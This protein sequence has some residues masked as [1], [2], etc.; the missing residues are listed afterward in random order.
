MLV[1]GGAGVLA[2]VGAVPVPDA[3]G[4]GDAAGAAEVGELALGASGVGASAGCRGAVGS[5]ALSAAGVASVT[6]ALVDDELA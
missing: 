4:D 1:V 2:L 6:E 3:F 5:G